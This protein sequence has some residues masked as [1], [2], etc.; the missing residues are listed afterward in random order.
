MIYRLSLAEANQWDDNAPLRIHQLHDG[1]PKGCRP[2]LFPEYVDQAEADERDGFA[3]AG[4]AER[5]LKRQRYLARQHLT[6]RLGLPA[7]Q[8]LTARDVIRGRALWRSGGKTVELVDPAGHVLETIVPAN[9]YDR[10]GS[11]SQWARS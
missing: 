11:R 8:R 3:P 4:T 2:E 7:D 10:D 1:H 9:K 6:E 5:E